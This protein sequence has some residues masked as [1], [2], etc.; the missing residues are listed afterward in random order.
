MQPLRLNAG[1]PRHCRMPHLKT[2][3]AKKFQKNADRK[4]MPD[5]PVPDG[6]AVSRALGTLALEQHRAARERALAASAVAALEAKLLA[7]E[8]KLEVRFTPARARGTTAAAAPPPRVDA[9]PTASSPNSSAHSRCCC[10]RRRA[11][12]ACCCG[13]CT[14]SSTRCAPSAQAAAAAAAAP[15]PR[16]WKRQRC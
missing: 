10:R 11:S 14:C 2:P 4:K 16:R 12:M 6:G 9:R 8:A 5:A 13:A 3:A 15:R 1:M 7:A